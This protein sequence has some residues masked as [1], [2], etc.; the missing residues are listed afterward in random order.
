MNERRV[1]RGAAE[2]DLPRLVDIYNH[3]VINTAITFDVVPYSPAERRPWFEQF[4]SGTRHELLVIEDAGAVMGY[5]SS[6]PLR[7]KQAYET[8]VETTIYLH[9]D[10]TGKG[11]GRSLYAHLIDTIASRDV[12]RAYG[13]VALPN[14]AS[15]ALHESLGFEQVAHLHEVGRKFDRYWDTVWLEK[16]L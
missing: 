4:R 8:S 10:A 7:P 11:L 12:H 1:I 9:P 2:S 14:D 16:R 6:A 3:Y 5:A 13:I 15:I